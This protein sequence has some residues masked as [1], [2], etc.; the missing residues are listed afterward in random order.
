MAPEKRKRAVS[1]ESEPAPSPSQAYMSILRA[2]GAEE[3]ADFLTDECERRVLEA[4]ATAYGYGNTAPAL[5]SATI[6]QQQVDSARERGGI[7][8][9]DF[10]VRGTGEWRWPDAYDRHVA[11]TRYGGLALPGDTVELRRNGTIPPQQG[12]TQNRLSFSSLT[13]PGS[14]LPH[15][16]LCQADFTS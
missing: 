11:F 5:P 6:R 15:D 3:N 14:I 9:P 8:N 10:R 2:M 16:R 1:E 7:V 13:A 4:A 12:S